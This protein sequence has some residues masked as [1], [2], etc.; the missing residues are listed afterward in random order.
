[1]GRLGEPIEKYKLP[2]GRFVVMPSLG[3]RMP[4]RHVPLRPPGW[5]WKE[6]EERRKQWGRIPGGVIRPTLL[7]K[8]DTK[9]SI[10]D[11]PGRAATGEKT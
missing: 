9:P 11:K 3:N 4:V 5:N 2:E 10:A 1:M 6:Q 7:A 8:P